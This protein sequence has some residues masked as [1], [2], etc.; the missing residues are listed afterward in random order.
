MD[1]EEAVISS[2]FNGAVDNA[3][4][5]EI[6]VHHG[7]PNGIDVGSGEGVTGAA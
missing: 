3:D 4:D 6:G 7:R 5:V 2:L 1:G